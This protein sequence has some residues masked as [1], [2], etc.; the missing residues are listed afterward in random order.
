MSIAISSKGLPPWPILTLYASSA[1]RTMTFSRSLAGGIARAGDVP[2]GGPIVFPNLETIDVTAVGDDIFGL[3]HNVFA[4]S[5]E[6]LHDISQ[7]FLR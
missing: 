4:P 5:R 6:V 7:N 1:D 3:N 2:A